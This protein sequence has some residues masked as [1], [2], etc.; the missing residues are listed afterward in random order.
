MKQLTRQA[1]SLLLQDRRQINKSSPLSE[2]ELT[3]LAARGCWTRGWGTRLQ[4]RE[5]VTVLPV[6]AFRL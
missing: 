1:L 2:M 5:D 4:E 3:A 6:V